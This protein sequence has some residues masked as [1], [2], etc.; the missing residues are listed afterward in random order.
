MTEQEWLASADP[1]MMIEFIENHPCGS[2]RKMRLFSVACYR[3]DGITYPLAD[4]EIEA[5]EQY[6]DGLIGMDD[7]L[8]AHYAHFRSLFPNDPDS[9]FGLVEDAYEYAYSEVTCTA[10]AQAA[11][12]SLL[13]D[14]FNPFRSVTID[15]VWL[16]WNDGTVVKMAQT[17]YDD[18][19]F[20]D[21]PIWADALMKAGCQNEDILS[22]C[23]NGGPH[24]RGCW[25]VDLI[26]GKE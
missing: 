1:T 22:H 11:G 2:E 3:Q 6:A 4:V 20:E 9:A 26:L 18:R 25:A 16:T 10:E 24:V 15:P 21:L 13:R 8:A 12:A 17:I 7:L 23:R 5:V 19:R 14:I